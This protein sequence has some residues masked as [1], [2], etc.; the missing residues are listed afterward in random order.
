[1]PMPSDEI[2]HL[3]KEAIPDAQVRIHDLAGDN[4]HFQAE[5]ISS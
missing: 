4:D 5:V 1:M 2:E 3:I